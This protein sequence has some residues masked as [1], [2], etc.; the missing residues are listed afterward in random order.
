MLPNK[1]MVPTALNESGAD[2]QRA[3]RRPIGRPLGEEA[4]IADQRARSAEFGMEGRTSPMPTSRKPRPTFT[5]EYELWVAGHR[6]IAGADEVGV[7]TVAGPLVAAAI[8]L[9]SCGEDD[10]SPTLQTLAETWW[11]VRDSKDI[12][13]SKKLRLEGLIRQSVEFGIGVVE[14]D[15]RATVVDQNKVTRLATERAIDALPRSPSAILL[16]GGVDVPDRDLVHRRIWKENDATTSLS[17][18]AASIIANIHFNRIMCA[19]EVQYPG[20]GFERHKGYL[21]PQ[22]REALH[23]L[24]PCPIHH[25]YNKDVRRILANRAGALGESE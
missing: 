19:Y 25:L 12:A 23:R 20:Y 18:S 6:A 7:G 21:T 16:D 9:P 8:L 3:L 2:P 24:G 13:D 11:E 1:P 15:E 17:I 4:S 14:A 10:I 5:V 22:H